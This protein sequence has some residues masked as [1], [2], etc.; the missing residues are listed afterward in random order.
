MFNTM[1]ITKAAGAI[2]GALLFLLLS[3]WMA[4]SIFD[5]RIAADH[6]TGETPQAY[7]IELAD[8]DS[9]AADAEEEVEVDFDALMAD[10]DPAAG[11]KSFGKCRACHKLD[12]GNA[13][14]PH[15]DGV[16]G[17]PIASVDGFA[18][19]DAMIE[20]A[21]DYPDWSPEA[22]YH[23][24]TNPKAEVPGTKM[25]FAGFKKPQEIADLVA[26]LEQNP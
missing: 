6:E 1:T 16:V 21:N 8:A 26:Y 17:R 24:L 3:L 12:G 25:V 2:I 18:Y 19:S 20:H 11:E 4:S 14:G 13:T 10:A 7:T 23:F 5:M 15:L 9:S 22:L